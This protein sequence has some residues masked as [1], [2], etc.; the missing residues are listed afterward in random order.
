MKN[1][2]TSRSR[3]VTANHNVSHAYVYNNSVFLLVGIAVASYA[4]TLACKAPRISNVLI[5]I[6]LK[7][8]VVVISSAKPKMPRRTPH[9]R[10]ALC[11]FCVSRVCAHFVLSLSPKLETTRS[12][13]RYSSDLTK[14]NFTF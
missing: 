6:L 14:M 7:I 3:L 9:A 4:I 11:D 10:G 12:L 13:D 1:N 8:I 5:G 2:F